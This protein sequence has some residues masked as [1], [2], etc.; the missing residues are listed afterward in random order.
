M[1]LF[2]RVRGAG[3][4]TFEVPVLLLG[5]Y[6][7]YLYVFSLPAIGRNWV[8][9]MVSNPF[10]VVGILCIAAYE[11]GISYLRD[12]MP[13]EAGF[14]ARLKL[15][16]PGRVLALY[17]KQRGSDLAVKVLGRLRFAAFA[18][19]AIGMLISNWRQISH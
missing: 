17:R 18:S 6:A 7:W 15:C 12:Q 2:R 14:L 8:L 5:G 9:S 19:F 11:I 13:D 16:V 10:G 1:L 3:R 4:L